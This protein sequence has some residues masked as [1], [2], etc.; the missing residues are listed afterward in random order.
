MDWYYQVLL[1]LTSRED[2]S[3]LALYSF[4]SVICLICSSVAIGLEGY[5]LSNP[6]SCL[7]GDRL[8]CALGTAYDFYNGNFNNILSVCSTLTTG[9]RGDYSRVLCRSEPTGKVGF[10]QGKLVLNI[11]MFLAYLILIIQLGVILCKLTNI[12]KNQVGAVD[13]P[14]PPQILS[15]DT[16]AHSI[17]SVKSEAVIENVPEGT[18]ER[19]RTTPLMSRSRPI[20]TAKQMN[21]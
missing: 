18:N 13:P 10:T 9:N 19:P 14:L 3:N 21:K 5:F 20:T 1:D 11:F 4:V 12:R 15:R 8:C 17:V 16:S 2:R 7:L 6:C